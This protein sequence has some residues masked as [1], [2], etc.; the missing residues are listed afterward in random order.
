MQLALAPF[1]GAIAFTY[2]CDPT[3]YALN[4]ARSGNGPEAVPD[5]PINLRVWVEIP[6]ESPDDREQWVELAAAWLIEHVYEVE[7]EIRCA[8][9]KP[10]FLN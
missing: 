3:T 9:I 6:V 7:Q 8:L 4:Q 10:I 1:P 2:I 5:H